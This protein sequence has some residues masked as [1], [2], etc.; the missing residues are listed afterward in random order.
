[1]DYTDPRAVWVRTANLFAFSSAGIDGKDSEF[2]L[3]GDGECPA[4]GSAADPKSN[5]GASD[6]GAATARRRVANEVALKCSIRQEVLASPGHLHGQRMNFEAAPPGPA[7][8]KCLDR[9]PALK[10]YWFDW[11]NY[12]PETTNL[13][14]C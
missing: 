10:D 1:M 12:H 13:Q 3:K 5:V 9:V 4:T 8:R 2:F 7:Q 11:R 6:T 14:A